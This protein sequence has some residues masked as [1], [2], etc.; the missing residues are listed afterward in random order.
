MIYSME[1]G[2]KRFELRKVE[3]VADQSLVPEEF[4]NMAR[5]FCFVVQF[6]YSTTEPENSHRSM[7]SLANVLQCKHF[8]IQ[9]PQVYAKDE[10]S[11]LGKL[12]ASFLT[13]EE[14]PEDVQKTMTSAIVDVTKSILC[15]TPNTGHKVEPVLVQFGIVKVTSLKKSSLFTHVIEEGSLTREQC[16]ICLEELSSSEREIVGLPCSHVYHRNCITKWLKTTRQCPICRL[17]IR[18]V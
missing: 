7:E 10:D 15:S 16:V 9:L 12:S 8:H 18:A 17:A 2:N 1:Y 5:G 13:N 11:L 3:L 14:L 4:K 6:Y